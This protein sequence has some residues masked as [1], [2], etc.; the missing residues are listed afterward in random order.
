MRLLAGALLANAALAGAENF[1]IQAGAT[2]LRAPRAPGAALIQRQPLPLSISDPYM[3]VY[4]VNGPAPDPTG[5]ETLARGAGTTAT[6]ARAA[7]ADAITAS[8]EASSRLTAED[9]EGVAKESAVDTEATKQWAKQLGQAVSDAKAA[10]EGTE[11]ALKSTQTVLGKA[12]TFM[13]QLNSKAATR[14]G[15]KIAKK[16]ATVYKGLQEWKMDVL[17][18]PIKIG[19]VAGMKAAAPYE[20]AMQKTERRIGAYEQRAKAL[21]AT[22]RGLRLAAVGTAHGAVGKQGAGKLKAASQGMVDAGQMI[23]QAAQLENQGL[24]MHEMAETLQLNIQAY[25]AAAQ[26]AE[27]AVVSRY[28]KGVYA[29]PSTPMGAFADRKSVV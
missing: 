19:R 15:D 5:L 3:P 20:D 22:A 26:R 4:V 18:N 9:A 6:R 14:T 21:S 11:I 8:A 25:Q 2:E 1:H 29:P 27:Q 13:D 24:K 23:S 17:H 10:E 16:L 12:I 28:S 7:A